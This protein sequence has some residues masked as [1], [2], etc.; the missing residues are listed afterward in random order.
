[1]K[2]KNKNY[3]KNSIKMKPLT[4]NVNH[5]PQKWIKKKATI[6]I[7]FDDAIENESTFNEDYNIKTESK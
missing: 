7:N 5:I 3:L 6:R 2:R 1:M 4:L